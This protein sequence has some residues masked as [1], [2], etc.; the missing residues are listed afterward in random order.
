[1]AHHLAEKG[2]HLIDL[3]VLAR[4]SGAVVGR[5]E[6]R[7]TDEVDEELLRGAVH[8]ELSALP[9]DASVLLVGHLA[10]LMP[11]DHVVVLRT[12]PRVLRDRLEA[13]G[14]PVAKV[15]EN[16]EAE[17]VGVILVEAMELEPSV[18]VL[19]VDTTSSTSEETARRIAV[20]LDGGGPGLEA[21]R[22]DWS[23]E[24]MGWY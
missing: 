9:E 13:R 24:V 5:D 4:R 18:P 1:M 21:G 8:Q 22:V 16:V 6:T 19:E 2:W 15:L 14:W 12:S 10:H 11:C 23:E 7:Q 20:A 3:T 17:A